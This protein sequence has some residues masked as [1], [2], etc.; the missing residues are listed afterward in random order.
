MSQLY[1]DNVNDETYIWCEHTNAWQPA[2]PSN[3]KAFELKFAGIY[4]AEN[5][6][7]EQFLYQTNYIDNIFFLERNKKNDNRH[8]GLVGSLNLIKDIKRNNFDKIIIFNSSVRFNLIAKL[9]GVPEI[10]QYPLF[11][12]TKQHI[13]DTPRKFIKVKR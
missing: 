2:I 3:T 13:T 7:V 12:K 6:K 8:D 4:D 10:Y 1:Y 9:S 5:S 11:Q